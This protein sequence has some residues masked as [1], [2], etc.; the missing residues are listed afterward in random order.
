MLEIFDSACLCCARDDAHGL[1]LELLHAL[2]KEEFVEAAS[3][4]Q[5]IICVPKTDIVTLF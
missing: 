3:R 5:H 4:L 1:L 2:L